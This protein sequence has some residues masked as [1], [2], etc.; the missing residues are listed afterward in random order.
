[1]DK[2]KII[3]VPLFSL[4]M[5]MHVF[6]IYEDIKVMAPISTIKIATMIHR[7]LIVCFYGLFVFLYLVRRSA[8]STTKSFTAKTV[9]VAATFLPFVIPVLSR[10]VND[11]GITFSANLITVFGMVITLYSLIA[12]GRSLSIIPQARTVVQTGPYQ[13]VRH[14]VYLGELIAIL[15]VVMARFSFSAAAVFCLLAAAQ[16]YRALQE[17]RVLAVTFPEYASYSIKR[18]R[19]IPGIF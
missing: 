19:F 16:V 17:E 1:M 18:A 12:L 10:P 14:P 15:G 9:A 2:G 4:L 8:L 6:G 5:I 3:I 13:V 11:P 7:L